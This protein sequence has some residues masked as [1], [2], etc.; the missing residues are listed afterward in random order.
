[1]KKEGGTK[2]GNFLRSLKGVAP[3]VLDF[4][5]DLTGLDQLR[6]LGNA[7]KGSDTITP[8]DKETALALLKMDEAEFIEI[9]KRWESDNLTDS[10]LTK[11][12][13]PMAL[14]FLTFMFTILMF[15]D[16]ISNLAFDVKPDYIDLMKALLITVYFAYFGGRSYE[17]YARIKN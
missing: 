10:F 16:S 11:N 6:L 7:I 17:K 3:E 8:K 5:A 13:R 14:V 2:V 1:M 9:T 4:A 15:T 12:V